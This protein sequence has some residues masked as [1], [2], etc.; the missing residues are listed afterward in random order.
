MFTGE[1]VG[2]LEAGLG[3]LGAPP[4]TSMSGRPQLLPRPDFPLSG[5]LGPGLWASIHSSF[6]GLCPRGPL[7]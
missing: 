6:K 7:A 5:P 2:G 1:S 4:A 3:S